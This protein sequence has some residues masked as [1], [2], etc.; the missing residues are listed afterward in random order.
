MR[1]YVDIKELKNMK[2]PEL[3]F[4][5]R[6]WDEEEHEYVVEEVKTDDYSI[7]TVKENVHGKTM[8]IIHVENP[9]REC[10]FR[11]GQRV[12]TRKVSIA[13][14]FELILQEMKE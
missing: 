13:E 10:R 3:T 7:D 12:E 9:F 2:L 5:F 14:M 11:D 8:L 1:R 4:K 6:V